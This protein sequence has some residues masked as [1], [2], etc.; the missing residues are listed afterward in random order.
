MSDTLES[1]QNIL[2]P[3]LQQGVLP[4]PADTRQA[5]KGSA[6]VSE[7]TLEAL[8]HLGPFVIQYAEVNDVAE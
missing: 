4:P 8:L 2:M 7:S 6:R 1:C 5:G 3:P